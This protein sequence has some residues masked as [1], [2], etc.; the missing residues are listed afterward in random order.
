MTLIVAGRIL[1]MNYGAT[2]RKRMMQS[3]IAPLAVTVGTIARPEEIHPPR[4]RTNVAFRPIADISCSVTVPVQF[5]VTGMHFHLPKPLHGWR[6]FA[7][8][9]GIIV[10]G[11]LI[12]IG[13]E[14]TASALHD[15]AIKREA[16]KSVYSEVSQNVSYMRGRMA[17]QGC[18]ER[19]LDE[20]G[21]LLA[22]A[23][24]G[25]I[26]PEPKWIGQ[27]AIWFN[28]DERWQAATGSGRAS[29]FSPD[30]QSDL[31]RIYVATKRFVD[32]EEREQTAWAQLRGLET[33]T[34][35]LGAAG[36]VHFVSALQAARLE[37][38]DTRVTAEVAFERA[39]A[40]GLGKAPSKTM[41]AGYSI[42]HA[43]CL[44]IDTPRDKALQ[45]LSANSPPWGQPK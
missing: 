1:H 34:G 4:R 8:E 30:E 17:T 35:P 20:V 27:P 41:V 5:G 25:A 19:R 42:P 18:V 24:D 39:T 28:S 16:H 37:L 33:W 23:G 10:L 12:A 14:Q 6:E 43:V 7:G 3:C 29:L 45:L 15:R 44:P 9:V 13:V 26:S 32:A 36:R 21:S 31:A 38:W 11:V 2:C 22:R 40:L